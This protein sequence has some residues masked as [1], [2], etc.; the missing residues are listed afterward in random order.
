MANNE[1]GKPSGATKSNDGTGVPGGKFVE[2]AQRDEELTQKY[3]EDDERVAD[4]I[5]RNNP[6]RNTGKDNATNAGG[7][8][9]GTS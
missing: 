6:N 3:T 1:T 7:Y 9:G 4:D 8:K 5:R 2:D